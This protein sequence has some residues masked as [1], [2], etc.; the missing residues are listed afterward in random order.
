MLNDRLNMPIICCDCRCNAKKM[1]LSVCLRCKESFPSTE[2]MTLHMS[3]CST[4]VGHSGDLVVEEGKHKITTVRFATAAEDPEDSEKSE[5][6]ILI[7][8]VC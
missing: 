5:Y 7:E 1:S 2:M 8:K 4:L 3:T 6:D